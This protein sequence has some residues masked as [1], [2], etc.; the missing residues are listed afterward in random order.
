MFEIPKFTQDVWSE[1]KRREDRC[2][3]CSWLKSS[4]SVPR[5][6]QPPQVWCQR[7]PGSVTPVFAPPVASSGVVAAVAGSIT[8]VIA[9]PVAASS[10]VVAAVAG[11][12]NPVIPPTVAASARSSVASL[13]ISTVT[14]EEGGEEG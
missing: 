10:G 6:R 1:Q 3:C 8:P 5:H 14:E 2:C 11:S 13:W 12:V 9:L 7:Y 4:P